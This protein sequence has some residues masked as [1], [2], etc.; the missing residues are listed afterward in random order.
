MSDGGTAARDLHCWPDSGIEIERNFGLPPAK[1][2][3]IRGIFGSRRLSD[4]CNSLSSVLPDRAAK[5]R[6]STRQGMSRDP[7]SE[8]RIRDHSDRHAVW[9]KDS[10]STVR[11]SAEV[12]IRNGLPRLWRLAEGH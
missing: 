8:A 7:R 6:K 10:P 2:A 4:R 3:P 5:A 1:I 12:K 9:C 11:S